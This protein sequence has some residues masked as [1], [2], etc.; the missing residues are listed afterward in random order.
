MDR[1]PGNLLIIIDPQRYEKG[2]DLQKANTMI[3]FDIEYCPLKM[4]QRIGRIDRIRPSSQE[5]QI[6]IVSF[7]PQ[8]NMSGYVINFFANELKMFTQWMGETTGIVSVPE[9]NK[10]GRTTNKSEA[11]EDKVHDLDKFYKGIYNLC[12]G[13]LPYAAADDKGK[14]IPNKDNKNKNLTNPSQKNEQSQELA[15]RFDPKK[16]FESVESMSDGFVDA[17]GCDS[18]RIESDFRFLFKLRESFDKAFRESMSPSREGFSLGSTNESVMRFNCTAGIYAPCAAG[19]CDSCNNKAGC[20]EKNASLRNRCDLFLEAIKSFYNQG[21][22]FYDSERKAF[23]KSFNATTVR[24][25]DLRRRGTEH[26]NRLEQR[27]R[28]FVEGKS[29]ADQMINQL[30]LKDRKGPFTVPISDFNKL[31]DPMKQ[32]YWDDVVMTYIGLI[33]D[34]FHSQCDSVLKSATLFE[35]FVKTLAVADFMNNME[36]TV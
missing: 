24:D 20:L 11:F 35:K 9:E 13:T 32:L 34:R 15:V 14:N 36:G 19:K 22:E 21:M 30:K 25:N 29:K 10:T 7:V 1:Y 18:F 23:D 16:E 17:F 26:Q 8:N 28:Q 33:L 5:Q 4:E 3:N 6:S 31:F 12:R 2:V 27:K